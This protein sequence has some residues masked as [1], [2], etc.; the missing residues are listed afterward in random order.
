MGAAFASSGDT[1]G[2]ATPITTRDRYSR[3]RKAASSAPTATEA[4]TGTMSHHL[5]RFVAADDTGAVVP[6]GTLD[7]PAPGLL[8]RAAQPQLGD[9]LSN[10]VI[11]TAGMLVFCVSLVVLEIKRVELGDYLPSLAFAPLLTWLFG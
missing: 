8:V 5:R 10:S 9:A 2:S 7:Q 11:A 4:A 3:G 6:G 1:D